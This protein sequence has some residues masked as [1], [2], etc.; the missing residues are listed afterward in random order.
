MNDPRD[1][2]RTA[3]ENRDFDGARSALRLMLNS[4]PSSAQI[5]NAFKLVETLAKNL[6]LA[7]AKLSVLSTFTSEL[8]TP[9]IFLRQFLQGRHVEIQYVQYDQ[10]YL[11]LAN[12]GQIDEFDPDFVL[13]LLHLDDVAPKVA[14][15]HLSEWADL[16]IE[17]SQLIGAIRTAVESFQARSNATIILSTFISHQSGIERYFDRNT[18]HSKSIMIEDYNREISK[19]AADCDNVYIFDYADTVANYGRKSWFDPVRAFS[20][21]SSVSSKAI[22]T[23]STEISSYISALQ[24]PR[25]KVL[26]VD[27][28]NTIWGGIVGE[29][30]PNGISVG[31][32][33]PGNAHSAFQQFLKNLRASG[34]LLVAASKNDMS[35]ARDAFQANE[36]MPLNW[37]D[38]ASHQINWDYKYRNLQRAA[39]ELNVGVDSFVF[40]DDS[41][42]E[43]EMMRNFLPEVDAILMDGS[44][45]TFSRKIIES[46]VFDT[47]SITQED[48]RRNK[49]YE[50]ERKRSEHKNHAES[51]DQFLAELNLEL[52]VNKTKTQN[53]ERITQL[54]SK[55]NQFNLTTK[56]YSIGEIHNFIADEIHTI[57]SFSLKDKYDDY[58]IISVAILKKDGNATEID[59]FLMSCRALGRN[60]ETAILAVIEELAREA[61]ASEIVGMYTP[62]KKNS[63]VSKF[64]E[65]NGFQS[66]D[67][68][69]GLVLN[70]QE[71]P[72]LTIPPHVRLVEIGE[73]VDG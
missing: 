28:D 2:L 44:P 11:A 27:F 6:D 34:V 47:V 9:I 36:T 12:P 60:I 16:E 15:A 51:I 23:L 65:S 73:N 68:H 7:V 1:Q 67:K 56:R 62:T 5:Y 20:T 13:L 30:G 8:L 48:L 3:C 4:S 54:I 55:T 46:G 17:R 29:D 70:L 38:F 31:G 19:V 72:S 26:A 18:S 42:I 61:A 52:T 14:Q 10:W 58:G 69:C 25:K 22:S 24:K 33:Y 63:L 59:S 40:I 35:D 41:P 49:S 45:A 64:Y 43:I 39:E 21:K 66:S 32:D 37:D 71:Q 50:A 53:I 57:L